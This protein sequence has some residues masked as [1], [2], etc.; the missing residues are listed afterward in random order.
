MDPTDSGESCLDRL[1]AAYAL[2]L[3][4]RAAGFADREIAAR[5]EV[6]PEA[7]ETLFAIAE[8]KLEALRATEELS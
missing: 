3:R 4:L 7:L 1:P 2:A 5:L 8:A 6:E